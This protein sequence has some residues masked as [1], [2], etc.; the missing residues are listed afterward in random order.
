MPSGPQLLVLQACNDV[1]GDPAG[2]VDEAEIADRTRLQLRD[3]R[4]CIESLDEKG[5]VTSARLTDRYKARI[6]ADGR[7]VL[8]QHRPFADEPGGFREEQHPVKVVP[9]GLRAFDEH[10]ADFFLELLPGPRRADGLPDSIHFWKVRIEEMDLDKTFKVGTVFGPS[11]CG[12]TSLVKAGLLPRLSAVV[13]PIYIQATATE[14][15]SGLLRGVRKHLPHLS[16]DTDLGNALIAVKEH[17]NRDHRKVLLVIDQF[18]QWLHANR[19]QENTELARALSECDGERVQALVMVRDDFSM[20]LFRFLEVL[21]IDFK[22]GENAYVIHRFD[23][24]HARKVLMAFGRAYGRLPAAGGDLTQEQKDFLEQAL[25][26]LS[27]DGEVVP[28]RL[29]LFAEMVGEMV[30]GRPWTPATLREVGG[31]EGVGVTFLEKTFNSPKDNPNYHLHQK[32]AQGV[33]KALLPESGT[34]IKGHMRSHE[35]LLGS[36]RYSA[37]PKAFGD[38]LRILDS[39]TRLITPIDP[40][41]IDESAEHSITGGK[42]YQLTHDYL[43]PSIREWLNRKQKETR[44]GRAEL[45]LAELSSL[46][47][48]KP[49]NR[50]L[51]SLLEWTNI[52]LLTKKKDWTE[53]QRRMMG[54]AAR[55]HGLRGLGMAALVGA[56]IAGGS[57]VHN[58]VAESERA[59]EADG[60]VTQV[61]KVETGKVPGIVALMKD[62]RRWVDPALKEALG[63]AGKGS[64]E[65]LHA[66]LAL[67]PADASHVEPLCDRMVEAEDPDDAT[68]I[69]QA[70]QPH[71][72]SLTSKL[73]NTVEHARTGEKSI[74]PAA[75]ALALYDP[76]NPHWVEVSDKVAQA[77]ISVSPVFLRDWLEALRPVRASLTAPLAAIF[78]DKKR[79]GTEGILAARIL[80]DYASDDPNLV[81]NLL[82]DADPTAYAAFFPIAQKQA[83]KTLPLFQAEIRKQA[84]FSWDDP[85]LDPAWTKPDTALAGKLEMGEGM[86]TE[87]FAFCQT[88]ALDEF[89]TTAEGLRNSGYRPIRFRPYADGNATRV[90]AVW[91][92][93]GRPWRLAHDQ[94]ADKIREADERNRKEDFIPVDVAADEATTADSK[95]TNRYTALWVKKAAP[96]DDAGMAVPAAAAEL[97]KVQAQFESPEWLL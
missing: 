13:I 29:A 64:S 56:L 48:A 36:S 47:N 59:T 1:P 6:T 74:L 53:P 86:L 96:G 84:T 65:E 90:A 91:T 50:R 63:K 51:P 14:T 32:A 76:S 69:G 77:L 7:Q 79:L 67:L 52:G 2:F 97:Q 5:Y 21:G 26:G 66:R 62:Y 49:E 68:V 8:R 3:V 9:K 17:I 33:L 80:A 46:W 72:E 92:R 42:Y 10:D 55:V 41:G 31:T 16:G 38:L 22:K 71:R 4:D 25:K 19:G 11:G 94:S 57:Y 39:E 23:H 20:A 73:W 81:A 24:Q 40:E 44:R 15:E 89:L 58:Q 37:R 45:R 34:N 12:K 78:R 83:A 28:V 35:E 43:V 87:R 27:Q 60:L 30:G 54:K 70:L 18:E 93:D 61:L 95:P 75:S 82:M 88:T 85:P